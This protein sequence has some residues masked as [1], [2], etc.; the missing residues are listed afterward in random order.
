VGISLDER[1]AFLGSTNQSE[2]PVRVFRLHV[3][4]LFLAVTTPS[5]FGF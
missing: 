1:S 2:C 5:Q 4:N 3:A